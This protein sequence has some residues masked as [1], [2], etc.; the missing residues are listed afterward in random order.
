MERGQAQDV[1]AEEEG[2]VS[3]SFLPPPSFPSSQGR[4]KIDAYMGP[5][6]GVSALAHMYEQNKI[7]E[8]ATSKFRRP[9]ALLPA[10]VWLHWVERGGVRGGWPGEPPEGVGRVIFRLW[11]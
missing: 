6:A 1:T 7:A 3:I 4:V 10:C 8:P 5:G 2:I 9:K 11:G